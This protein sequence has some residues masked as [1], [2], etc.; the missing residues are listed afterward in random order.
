VGLLREQL[1]NGRLSIRWVVRDVT[2]GAAYVLNRFLV[3][4]L[5]ELSKR[6]PRRYIHDEYAC[7]IRDIV[8]A[9]GSHPNG[10]AQ[11]VIGDTYTVKIGPSADKRA[12]EIPVIANL[13]LIRHGVEPAPPV[14]NGVAPVSDQMLPLGWP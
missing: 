10:S 12:A 8:R 9:D 1:L 7:E 6:A 13:I 14:L 2:P 4:V 5:V 11:L 3:L